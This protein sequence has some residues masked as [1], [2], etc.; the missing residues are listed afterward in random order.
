M[1]VDKK[2]RYENLPSK[3]TGEE[4]LFAEAKK[5]RI[6]E[7]LE[8]EDWLNE[9][10]PKYWLPEED[11]KKAPSEEAEF[12]RRVIFKRYADSGGELN[13]PNFIKLIQGTLK[14][15]KGVTDLI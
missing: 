14:K 2:I 7:L 10:D 1:P 15:D 9:I 8:L 12:Q 13:Y 5:N 4:T 11:D 6:E 3:K